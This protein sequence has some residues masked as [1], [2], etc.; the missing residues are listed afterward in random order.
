MAQVALILAVLTVGLLAP[1]WPASARTA[2][3]IAGTTAAALGLA[4]AGAGIRHLG[5]SLT[6]FP[7]PAEGAELREGGVYALVRHPIY[8]GGV[9]VS[10][11]W[12]L[13]TSPWALVP[14]FLLGILFEGK[15]RRE[16]HWLLDRYP[17][18][19]AY[20]ARVPRRFIPYVI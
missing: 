2:T 5:A 14:T 17:G 16:E 1:D 4:L 3:A 19:G 15:R 12:S 6:P 8:G 7:A 11:G 18:Y 9:L 10:L 13:W 20:R